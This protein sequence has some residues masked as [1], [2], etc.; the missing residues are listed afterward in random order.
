M[1]NIILLAFTLFC[2]FSQAATIVQIDCGAPTAIADARLIETRLLVTDGGYNLSSYGH[3]VSYL[4]FQT[5]PEGYELST[6]R[7][8]PYPVVLKFSFCKNGESILV[9][10]SNSIKTAPQTCTCSV[11]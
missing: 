3:T 10:S 11:L 1:K 6:N 4:E 9:M 8:D 5:T 7:R 2:S